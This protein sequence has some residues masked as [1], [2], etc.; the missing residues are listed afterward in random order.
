MLSSSVLVVLPLYSIVPNVPVSE[1]GAK[2]ISVKFCPSAKL[3]PFDVLIC[4]TPPFSVTA[5]PETPR[6]E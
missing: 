3:N 4:S 2:V 1:P 5:P 6:L